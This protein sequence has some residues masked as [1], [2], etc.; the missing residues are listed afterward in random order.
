MCSPDEN[1]RPIHIPSNHRSEMPPPLHWTGNPVHHGGS[2]RID[3]ARIGLPGEVLICSLV[4]FANLEPIEKVACV[5]KE[6]REE[7]VMHR[8]LFTAPLFQVKEQGPDYLLYK[9]H[10]LLRL[11]IPFGVAASSM[12]EDGPG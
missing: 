5:L 12:G 3:L 9:L 11:A 6:P 10:G 1:W 7:I 8:Q 2:K 4:S